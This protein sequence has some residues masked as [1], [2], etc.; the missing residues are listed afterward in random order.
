MSGSLEQIGPYIRP[1]APLLAD[2]TVTDILVNQGGKR[3][4]IERRGRLEPTPI[5]LH[6]DYL[7][8]AI[9][10]IAR[11][12]GNEIDHTRPLLDARLDDGSRVAAAVPP[13]AA[14]GET[15]S[16]RKFTKRYTLDELV[17]GATL[18]PHVADLL[19]E[20]VDEQRNL[21]ISGGT[22]A[23]KTTLLNA[24]ARAIP[25]ADRLVVIEDTSELY[26]PLS[27]DVVRLEAQPA[28]PAVPGEPA[29]TA[30]TIGDLLRHALRHRPDRILVGEVRG[31]EAWDLLQC[32][33]T[34][35]LGSMSSIHANSAEQALTRLSHCVIQSNIN[36]PT[37]NI[38][39]AIALAIH[40]VI[41]IYRER[42]NGQRLVTDVLAVTGID[43]HTT[44]FQFETVY[45][46]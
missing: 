26:L 2:R 9:E 18:P 42:Q 35:H 41:H 46:R 38:L 44:R 45:S 24:L 36:L 22:G 40:R 15:L 17:E 23:G 37:V 39:E 1:L 12:C 6:Q 21:L 29:V 4:F 16:I 8:T 32:L 5:T 19:R 31:G 20:A 43:P 33:N 28:R 34:G 27:E 11:M 30:F 13:C 14:D 10:T 25:P 3:V 7:R